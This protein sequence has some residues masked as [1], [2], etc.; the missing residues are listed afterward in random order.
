MKKLFLLFSGLLLSVSTYAQQGNT[1]LTTL[2]ESR[3]LWNDANGWQPNL[4]GNNPANNQISV[5]NTLQANESVS[6][7][8]SSL[9]VKSGD[10]LFFNLADLSLTSNRADRT[11]FISVETDGFLLINGDLTMNRQS[12][13]LVLMNNGTVVVTGTTDLNISGWTGVA[14][15]EGAQTRSYFYTPPRVNGYTINSGQNYGGYSITYGDEND[16]MR[17]FPELYAMMGSGGAVVLPVE[18]QSFSAEAQ[19]SSV[20]VSWA[21]ASELNFSHFIVEHSTNGYTFTKLSQLN[22]QGSGS[23]YRYLHQ[24]AQAGLNY[25]RLTA[26]D[27]DGSTEV[28]G[29]KSV[30]MVENGLVRVIG[31]PLANKQ[32]KLNTTGLSSEAKVILR[33]SQGKFVAQLPATES[34]NLNLPAGMYLLTLTD[35]FYTEQHRIVLN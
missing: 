33:N 6:M 14:Y 35:G 4:P 20:N 27:I 17:D 32:L 18:L 9:T 31:N 1:A 10:T 19:T 16:F 7:T 24:Q 34:T 5:D 8:N 15:S 3:S 28:H 11:Y 23:S 12:G 22:A 13:N 21:T 29:T 2:P 26:V 25:Y 30:Y